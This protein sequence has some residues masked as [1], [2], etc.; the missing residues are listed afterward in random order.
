MF[1]SLQGDAPEEIGAG[2]AAASGETRQAH[3]ARQIVAT[4]TRA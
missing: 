2:Q 4:G 3:P 1:I